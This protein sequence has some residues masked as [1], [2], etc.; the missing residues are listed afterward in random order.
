MRR[1][2]RHPAERATDR[3]VGVVAAVPAAGSEKAAAHSLGLSHSTVK[4]HLANARSKVGATTTAQLVWFLAPRLP[5]PEGVAL[6][7]DRRS[8]AAHDAGATESSAPA[9]LRRQ[10]HVRA[11]RTVPD[12]DFEVV[13]LE[14]NQGLVF[15][16]AVVVGN[17]A[18]VE[19][20]RPGIIMEAGDG[21]IHC[22]VAGVSPGVELAD[23]SIPCSERARRRTRMPWPSSTACSIEAT[24]C[25]PGS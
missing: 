1:R 20:L 6:P 3:E 25:P 12:G 9:R 17:P 13:D 22:G 15:T 5:E 8:T 11:G 10:T 16:C 4:H 7:D 14:T 21:D 23:Q 24:S 18:E 2:P 19:A